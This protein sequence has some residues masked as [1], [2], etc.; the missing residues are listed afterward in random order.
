[1]AQGSSQWGSRI[2][3][4]LASAGS[5]IGLGAIWKFPYWAGVNGGS[6]F[7]LPFLFFTFTIGVALLI[8]EL[9]IGREGRG[10]AVQ[11]MKRLGGPAFAVLGGLA[12]LSAYVIL[13]YYSVVGGWCVA[14][15][16]DAFSG[17]L[18]GESAAQLSEQ[19]GALVADPVADVGGHV[20][21]LTL[22]CAVIALGVSSGI[23]KLAKYLMP[24]LFI[25]MVFLIGRAVTLPGASEGLAFLFAPD[26][27]K[28]SWQGMLN[29][30]GYTFFSLS[31]GAGIIVTY[32]C[33]LN[34]KTDI[35]GSAAWIA[36]LSVLTSIMAG[37]MI[38]P[39]VFAMGQD[40]GAGP[41]LVFV[42]IPLIFSQVPAGWL[43]SDLFYVCLLTAALTS[44]VSLLEVVVAYLQNEWHMRRVPATLLCYVTLAALGAVSA[45]SFGPWKF[46]SAGGKNFFELLDYVCTNVMMPLGGLAVALLAGWAAWDRTR[47]QINLVRERS[48]PVQGFYKLALRVF[49][50][51]LVLA[52][53][54]SGI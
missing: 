18:T 37:M 51:A 38:L 24:T 35:P 20:A 21:F 28:M 25:L 33:Y 22:T 16:L 31:L 1:M 32:G 30:M 45:L 36:F 9:A 50:P 42:T 5:A 44:S 54:I 41:G 3:F 15:L 26:F 43:F 52:V 6:A 29:A 17:G 13:S 47:R 8:G 48:A 46:L 2:G 40:P 10:S 34:E 11:A 7:I 53:L 49:S 39:A 4:I 27:S 23:E 14:Y 12:V 19:F